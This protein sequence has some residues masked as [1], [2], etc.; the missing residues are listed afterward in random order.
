MKRISIIVLILLTA[1]SLAS[2]VSADGDNS[3]G[4]FI[5]LWEGMDINDGSLRTI[6]ITDNERDGVYAVS[7]YDT[8]WSLCGENRG[9]YHG[10]G[11]VGSDGWLHVN[12]TLNCHPSGTST[13]LAIAY[14]P[15]RFSD[16][17][18]EEPGN[19]FLESGNLHRI[20]NR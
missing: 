7:I 13:S 9:A 20:S 10:T 4:Y 19:E 12:G 6:S 5:G 18:I 17:L 1:V 8:Y 16:T 2:L 3:N 14:R 11:T 15:V